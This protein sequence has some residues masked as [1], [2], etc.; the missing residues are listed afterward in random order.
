M[1]EQT[2]NKQPAQSFQ[3]GR[4]RASVWQ[5]EK[6]PR[7]SV[8]IDRSYKDAEDQWQRS[9]RYD[10]DDL[11]AVAFLAGKAADWIIEQG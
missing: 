10:A 5:N 1:T 6:G 11:P 7:Y 3:L 2:N 8:T 9:T 4:L